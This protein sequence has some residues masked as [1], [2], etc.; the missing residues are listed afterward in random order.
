MIIPARFPTALIHKLESVSGTF[1]LL[2]V[3]SGGL[4]A[5][6]LFGLVAM[7]QRLPRNTD[8]E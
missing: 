5:A 4:N 6:V 3:L 7:F 1:V 2:V 8:T